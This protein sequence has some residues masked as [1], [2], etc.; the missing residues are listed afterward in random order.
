MS[1]SKDII[2]ERLKAELEQERK[3]A[4]LYLKWSNENNVQSKFILI[5]IAYG[6]ILGYLAR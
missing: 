1:G 4:S 3:T 2:I 5:G 6:L